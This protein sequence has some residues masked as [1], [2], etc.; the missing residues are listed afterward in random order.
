MAAKRKQ[1]YISVNVGVD[2]E[3]MS[4][5]DINRA[6]QKIEKWLKE[7]CD[8]YKRIPFYL[9]DKETNDTIEYTS[10]NFAKVISKKSKLV[11]K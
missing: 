5:A 6:F 2:T 11:R 9:K 1:F 10:K 4:Q 7:S 8:T 3:G